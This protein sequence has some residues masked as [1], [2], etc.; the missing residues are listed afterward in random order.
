[1]SVCYCNYYYMYGELIVTTLIAFKNYHNFTHRDYNC[2]SIE[3]A[4][5]R[6]FIG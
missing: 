1:M 3:T 2:K 6:E 4:S 5:I